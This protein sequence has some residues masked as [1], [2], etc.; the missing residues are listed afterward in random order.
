MNLT[1]N[2]FNFGTDLKVCEKMQ[3]ATL[4]AFNGLSPERVFFTKLSNDEKK[5]WDYLSSLHK[6]NFQ[7]A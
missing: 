2:I 4:A 6:F 5:G 3:N 1:V 7:A